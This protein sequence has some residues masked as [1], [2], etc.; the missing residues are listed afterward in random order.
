MRFFQ[1]L[2]THF[3]A[4]CSSSLARRFPSL[5]VNRAALECPGAAGRDPV[6]GAWLVKW[7]FRQQLERLPTNRMPCSGFAPG[8]TGGGISEQ[9][10]TFGAHELVSVMNQFAARKINVNLSYS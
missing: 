4:N 9:E 8:I 5:P 6:G 1:P 10:L 2:A 7:A 3:S